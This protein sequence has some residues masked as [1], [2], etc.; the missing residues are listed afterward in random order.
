MK[1]SGVKAVFF[2]P[3]G[4][5]EKVVSCIAGQLAARLGAPL[6]TLDLTLPQNRRDRHSYGKA[7]L[8]VFGVPVYAGRVPNK[9]LP[10]VQSG[11]EGNGAL[12]LPVAAFGNR[13]FGDTLTELQSELEGHGFHTAAAAG[14]VTS[15]VFSNKLASGRPDADDLTELRAFA[16]AVA[17]KVAGLVSP[18]APISVEGNDPVGPYYTPL[19][20][21]GK[22]AR[23]LKA[24]P[25]TDLAKCT[26][27][28]LCARVCPMGSVSEEEPWEVPGVCIKCQACVKKCP[29]GAKYFDDPAFL[30]HVSMLEQ[31]YARRV[32]SRFFL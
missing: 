3:T 5:T 20:A 11:F 17:E 31:N 15:H 9:L 18:P 16:D 27:C 19:G 13:S 24:K 6:E 26:R 12:A 22:P 7:D 8:V 23:F 28:G 29:T 32:R 4:N 1:I 21:D 25:R 2:S 30:S 14:V 10:Y